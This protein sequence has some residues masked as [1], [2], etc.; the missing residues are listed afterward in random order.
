M[1]TIESTLFE[2]CQG[3]LFPSNEEIEEAMY[4]EESELIPPY[5]PDLSPGAAR[6][7]KDTAIGLLYRYDIFTVKMVISLAQCE[8]HRLTCFDFQV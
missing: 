3:R 2:K 5:I 4:D 7:T 1:R 8:F 6:I